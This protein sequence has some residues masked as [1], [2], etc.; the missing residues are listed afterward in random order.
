L[1]LRENNL[2]CLPESIGQLTVLNEL[3]LSENDFVSLPESLGQ[4]SELWLMNV[5]DCTY[6]KS[7]PKLPLNIYYIHA[8]GCKSL[9]MIPDLLEPSAVNELHLQNCFKLSENQDY[10]I[11]IIKRHLQVSLSLSLSLSLS[12]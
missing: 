3:H 10:F 12:R 1:D 8:E 5:T 6:L 4:L 11:A 7:L 9:E 2:K